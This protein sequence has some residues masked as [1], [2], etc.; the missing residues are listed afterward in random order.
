[1]T[2]KFFN[3]AQ[4]STGTTGTGTVTL[5]PHTTNYRSFAAAGAVTGDVVPYAIIDGSASECGVGTLTIA[6][7]V[8]TM[9]RTLT[10]S[11]TGA[12]LNLSGGAIV[13]LTP[14]AEDLLTPTLTPPS[15]S[16]VSTA[17]S[18]N[19]AVSK[20]LYNV[21]GQVAP[22]TITLPSAPIPGDAV[23]V[24]MADLVTANTLTVDAGSGRTI[25][26]YGQTDVVITRYTFRVYRCIAALTWVVES[27]QTA[28]GTATLTANATSTIVTNASCTTGSHISLSPITAHAANGLTSTYWIAGNGSF[29]IY[30]ASNTY[31][32]RN[33]TYAIL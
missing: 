13:S 10:G 27:N 22:V 17:V 31:T 20:T 28:K 30:H 21:T 16:V 8:T 33:Y 11:T 14:R 15:W 2:A 12:L 6:G 4:M 1:M 3:L 24:F 25:A 5:G 18:V 29:T 32:D 26:G 9:T 7:S 23:A 19:P